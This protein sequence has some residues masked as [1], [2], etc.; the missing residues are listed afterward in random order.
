MCVNQWFGVDQFYWNFISLNLF[1]LNSNNCLTRIKDNNLI[2]FLIKCIAHPKHMKTMHDSV[3]YSIKNNAP[4]PF[5]LLKDMIE[6]NLKCWLWKLF[7]ILIIIFCNFATGNKKFWMNFNK[8][9]WNSEM[10]WKQI[11]LL[12]HDFQ[13]NVPKLFSRKKKRQYQTVVGF[14]I[15]SLSLAVPLSQ[16]K[17]HFHCSLSMHKPCY[18]QK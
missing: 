4:I 12:K 7:A 10:D 8:I 17:P 15:N 18:G 13:Q 5:W 16:R 14:L 2:V 11:N 1:Q 3:L 6:I 9:S